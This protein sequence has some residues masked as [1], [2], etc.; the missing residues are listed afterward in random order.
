MD[1]V[2]RLLLNEKVFNSAVVKEEVEWF[3]NQL[4]LDPYYFNHFP[5][6]KVAHHLHSLIAAKKLAQTT[7]TK[8]KIEL[9]NEEP[10]KYASPILF[11]FSFAFSL[12]YYHII[13]T[14]FDFDLFV[15]FFIIIITL[16]C[17]LYSP[18]RPCLLQSLGTKN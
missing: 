3:Y 15:I 2:Y 12:F 8:E 4:G 14:L 17:L 13:F 9:S 5:L 6:D 7:G 10:T 16:Q 18:I 1:V 11:Y